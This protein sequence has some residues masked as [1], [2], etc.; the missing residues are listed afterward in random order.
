MTV[1]AKHKG[2]YHE[3]EQALQQALEEVQ[4]RIDNNVQLIG[5]DLLSVSYKEVEILGLSRRL[6][7]P[8][9]SGHFSFSHPLPFL[10]DGGISLDGQSTSVQVFR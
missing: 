6:R 1:I 10:A 5:F 7:S 4:L 3:M 9:V 2:S 8:E